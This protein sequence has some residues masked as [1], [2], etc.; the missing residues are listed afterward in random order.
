[1]NG[2]DFYCT[3]ANNNNNQ[4][5][6][7]YINSIYKYNDTTSGTIIAKGDSAASSNYWQPEDSH[8]LSDHLNVQDPNVTLPENLCINSNEE[9]ITPLSLFLST[10]AKKAS[11]MPGLKSSSLISI[12][13]LADEDCT[14]LLDKKS[15]SPL[16]IQK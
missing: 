5:V 14:I 9:G 7:P 8:I 3:P 2:R 6:N 4:L 10:Q 1:M 16:K 15:S 12:G 11:I 13:Q